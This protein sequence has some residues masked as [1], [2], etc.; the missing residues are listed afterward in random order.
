MDRQDE[1][2]L[3]GTVQ[4]IVFQNP[5][6]GYTV[7]RLCEESG[8][9][10]TVVGTI[11][12]TVVGE[13]LVIMGHWGTHASHGRQF[14]AEFL[15]RLMPEN[16]REILAY[17]S[18]RAVKGIGAKTAEKIVALFGASSL[19]VIE[20]EPEK[21]TQIS[22][23]S[24]KKAQEISDSFRRQAGIR[25]LIEFL[26]LHRLPAELAV[27][28]YR[29]YGELAVD[30]L[31]DDP[32]LLTDPY[33]GADFAAVDA[34]ALELDL[35]ADD[36]RRV[37]AGIL[38][39]LSYNLTNGHTFIPMP[40]LCAA[41]AALLNLEHETIEEGLR[42]L[43]EQERLVLDTVAGL[44]ACY[45]P[46]LYEAEVSVTQ[47]ILQMADER[48]SPPANLDAILDDISCAHTIRYAEL[49]LDAIRAAATN[50]LLI[51]TGGP[52]TGKTTVMTGILDL[53]DAMK[54]KTQ[55][56][57]PTGRAAKRLS[58]VTGR[59]AS[60]IHRLLEAQFDP[61][62][63]ALAFF[64]DEDEP[65]KA[66][67]MIVD[68]ASMIDLQLMASL[69]RALKPTCRLILV[70]DPDQL[71]SVGAGNLFSDL[72]RS[73]VA[74]TVR[75]T[76]IF[77][78]AQESLI[79]M[80]AHA[81]NAGQLPVL[82]VKDR[83]FFFMRRQTPESVVQTIQEL[84]RRRL[85]ENMGIPVSEI[86]VL[87]PSR[88]QPTGTKALNLALQA[89]LNPPAEG[90]RE[91]RF[92]DFSFREGDRVMQIR[93]NYD[94][95]WK[96]A[97]GFGSGTGIFNG[98]IGKILSIDFAEEQLTIQFDDRIAQYGFDMLRELELA[99]AMT[100]HK[101]QGS[102]YRAVILSAFS[103]SSL[104]LTRSVLYTAI[105]RARELFIIVGREE[106]IA[107]MTQNDRQ[108]RRYSA[109]KLRLQQGDA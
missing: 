50:R 68:E 31:R 94:I 72:I 1:Q 3:R 71:P 73:G 93:N 25:R 66:E 84:C 30:A 59:E 48:T 45:L 88:K 97:D 99:Y 85:P 60:T 100:V 70:G 7:L 109:L 46:E 101:S 52:G 56:A 57:A 34:F 58:E 5:E 74:Q 21:L 79:V 13:R 54:L 64:H 92:G 86:Q 2:M 102:E 37:E 61:E 49:Q 41:T 108:Q 65:L 47:R 96:K 36:E 63:G 90:K 32:Y 11:P 44:T 103:G 8:E 35:E 6:N 15:E 105:T 75:L 22:G 43:H 83:D 39:E 51:V 24:P 12:M 42:R 19:D 89:A 14:E 106:V 53:F 98:D 87:S 16:S 29:V 95:L 26:T 33:F 23:I 28:L 9:L 4:S 20:N 76:Q 80:N 10:I 69:L 82:T 17:L 81:V 91:K 27:R 104:L 18:S 78:Q 67:A 62:T 55:L 77:R 38:F 40:K 107:A